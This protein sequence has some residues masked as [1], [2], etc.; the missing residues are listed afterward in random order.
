MFIYVIPRHWPGAIDEQSQ[1]PLCCFVTLIV[2]AFASPSLPRPLTH[3]FSPAELTPAPL[4]L[5]PDSDPTV[6]FTLHEIRTS[7]LGR[8]FH[9]SGS[10]FLHGFAF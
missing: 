5:I 6:R 10:N 3:V 1:L 7:D 9:C 2:E 4:E 8:L